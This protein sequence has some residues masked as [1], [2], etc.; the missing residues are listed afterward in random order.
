LQYALGTL[1]SVLFLWLAFRGVDWRGAWQVI[2][3]ADVWLMLAALGTVLLT[4]ILKAVRWRLMFFPHHGRLALPKV[5]SVFLV[6]QFLNALIPARLGEVS[7][8]Y[9]MGREEGVSKLH[10]LWTTALE[11]VLD[12]LVLLVFLALLSFVVPLPPWLQRAGWTLSAA[13][14]AVLILLILIL[15]LR[16]KVDALLAH[17]RRAHPWLQH[18]RLSRLFATVADSVH[19]LRRPRLS[20][21]LLSWSVLAFLSA[22]V[23]NWLTARA[24][25]VPVSY[26]ASLLLLV[27]LQISAVVPIPTSPGRVG[28]FHY[29]CVISLA[30]FGVQREVA[31]SYGLVLHFLVYLPMTIGGPLGIW[32]ESVGWR[33]LWAV[34]KEGK[35]RDVG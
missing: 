14:L 29:L 35:A 13:A 6:G 12:A 5:F 27:V 20:A 2:A 25:D 21:G 8:A 3:K 22:T 9:L 28:L 34:G 26:Q 32:L 17:W 11:K 31:L 33:D 1:V 4:T 16:D 19:L 18:L 30:I 23:T 15:L 24:L 10:A 7:R